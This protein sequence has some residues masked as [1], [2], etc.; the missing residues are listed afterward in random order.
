MGSRALAGC[1]RVRGG[2]HLQGIL[3]EGPPG[4][5]KTY[6]AKAMAGDSGLPFYSASGSE[7]VEMFQGVAA[8]RVR[9]L[10]KAARAT[11]PSIVFI[12]T[13]P[14]QRPGLAILQDIALV[15]CCWCCWGTAP[16]VPSCFV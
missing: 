6:L 16:T 15:C 14:L 8:A 1:L 11:A 10:F 13:A 3:L 2:A 9:D 5:G 7:F 4:T 12:G